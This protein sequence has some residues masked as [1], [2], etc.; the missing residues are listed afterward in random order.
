MCNLIKCKHISRTIYVLI[1]LCLCTFS[2]FLVWEVLMK[3]ASKNSSFQFVSLPI[4]T[5]PIITIC[6]PGNPYLTYG[7]EFTIF[8]Y[9]SQEEFWADISYQNNELIEG[10]NVKEETYLT[11]IQ[12]AYMGKCFQLTSLARHI[13]TK[14]YQ[15]IVIKFKHENH[16]TNANLYFT[17]KSNANGALMSLWMDGDN[18]AIPLNINTYS[19]YGISQKSHEY[20]EFKNKCSLGEESFYECFRKTINSTIFSKCAT[21]CLPFQSPMNS[22]ESFPLCKLSEEYNCA[23]DVVWQHHLEV[24]ESGICKRPCTINEYH[25]YKTYESSS[26]PTTS[27]LSFYFLVPRHVT[28]RIEYLIFDTIG[29]FTAIGGTLGLCIGFSLKGNHVHG[30]VPQLITF[31]F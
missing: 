23:T 8:K 24:E 9:K 30:F 18:L 20:L 27:I 12:T 13:E 14:F 10:E 17:S 5:Y 1:Y 19:D 31:C 2:L 11:T 21:K 7:K 25:G 28:G 22:N 15:S 29:M 6:F 4:T 26:T 16:S 3:Y